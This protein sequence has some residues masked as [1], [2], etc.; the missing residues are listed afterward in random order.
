MPLLTPEEHHELARSNELQ[1]VHIYRLD[2][3]EL[4]ESIEHQLKGEIKLDGEW[5]PKYEAWANDEG[6]NKIMGILQSVGL[7]KNI[8]LGILKHD[9][10]YIRV[11]IIWKRL[12]YMMCVNYH[13]YGI[14]KS[15]RSM[16]IQLV[17]Q[18]VHS[19]LSRSELGREGKQ[20]S[21]TTQLIDQTVR[22]DKQKPGRLYNLF[23][24]FG[25]EPNMPR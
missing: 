15:H 2:N 7:N 16:L 5:T 19:A 24:G 8:T 21:S 20:L 6:V 3:K 9:E 1:S 10:I 23:S 11:N 25:R 14:L 18:Q 13:R 17:V 22:E 4:L 12:A